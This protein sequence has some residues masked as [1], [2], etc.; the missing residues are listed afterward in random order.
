VGISPKDQNTQDTIHREYEAQEE[1]RPQCG[2]FD[3]FLERGTKY[4]WEQIWRQ[5]TEKRLKERPPGDSSQIQS[6]NSDT[7]VD[8]KKSLLKGA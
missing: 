6:P 8:A 3:H 2:Y 7:I 5:S 4:S 1:G